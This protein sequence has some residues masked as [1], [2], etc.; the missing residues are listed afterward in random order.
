MAGETMDKC[1]HTV[2]PLA[3]KERDGKMIVATKVSG[4][5]S[6]QPDHAR[7]CLPT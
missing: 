3:V 6:R 5:F 4:S 7:L 2:E 1:R